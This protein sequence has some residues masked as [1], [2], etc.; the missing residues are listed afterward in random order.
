MKARPEYIWERFYDAPQEEIWNLWTDA[1]LF[2]VW[3]GPNVETI[4]HQ[5][6]VTE[7]G[8]ALIEMKWAEGASQYQKFEYRKV[9]PY[10]KLVWLQSITDEN[11][12]TI[13]YP[14]MEDW[15]QY[16][17]ATVDIHREAGKNCVHFTW[18]PFGD[19]TEKEIA[20]FKSARLDADAGW[21][22]ALETCDEILAHRAESTRGL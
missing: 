5:M 18:S 16:L 12:Q 4:V 20:C 9:A 3:Y 21:M 8:T 22:A 13:R 11:W 2:S 17:L 7:G 14:Q 19:V 15:P 1:E 10:E 6:T